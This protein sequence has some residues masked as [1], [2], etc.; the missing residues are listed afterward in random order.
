ML[1][2]QII[3]T[4]WILVITMHGAQRIISSKWYWWCK[5]RKRYHTWFHHNTIH[6]INLKKFKLILNCVK[7]NKL[8]HFYTYISVALNTPTLLCNHHY[9]P[10]AELLSSCKT[11]ASYPWDNSLLSSQPL[12]ANIL[13]SVY[14]SDSSRDLDKWIIQCLSFLWLPYLI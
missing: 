10:S 9:Q 11:G 5:K 1:I 13:L 8:Y 7:H 3:L 4:L 14:E 12:E 2:K 6:N